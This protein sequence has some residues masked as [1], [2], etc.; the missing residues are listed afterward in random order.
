[1]AQGE[2]SGRRPPAGQHDR[3]K[4]AEQFVALAAYGTL[5]AHVARHARTV[6]RPIREYY[7]VDQRATTDNA[8]N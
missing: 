5:A 3:A 7:L 4:A 6:D 8:A 1:M 2:R